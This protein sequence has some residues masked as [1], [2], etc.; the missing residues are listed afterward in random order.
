MEINGP[1]FIG[2]ILAPTIKEILLFLIFHFQPEGK[3][4]GFVSF[5]NI[6]EYLMASY[7]I[8]FEFKHVSFQLVVEE[9]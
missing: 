8:L 4:K 7:C 2:F 9:D 5:V 6:F 1:V 3:W